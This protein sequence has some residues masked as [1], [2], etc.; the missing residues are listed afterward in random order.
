MNTTEA[1]IIVNELLWS[2]TVCKECMAAWPGGEPEHHRWWCGRI[3]PEAQDLPTAQE[4]A[5][6]IAPNVN[7]Q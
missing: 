6:D 5:R 2:Y 1:L 4:A 7:E 3:E